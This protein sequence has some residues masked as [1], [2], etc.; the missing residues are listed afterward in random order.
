MGFKAFVN[1]VEIEERV[2]L[3]YIYINKDGNPST[4]STRYLEANVNISKKTKII[5]T[6]VMKW[7][8]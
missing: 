2:N 8:T 4:K 5:K 7:K 3:V 6:I 1:M